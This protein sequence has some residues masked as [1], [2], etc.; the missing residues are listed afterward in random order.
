M[1]LRCSRKNAETYRPVGDERLDRFNV[2]LSPASSPNL[3]SS[4][5]AASPV[6]YP[7]CR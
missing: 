5:S 3:E 7:S 6:P 2:H 1:I 4:S